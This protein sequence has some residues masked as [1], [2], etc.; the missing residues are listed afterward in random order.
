MWSG[1]D[2]DLRQQW[3]VVREMVVLQ[4]QTPTR[5]W[6]MVYVE[7]QDALLVIREWPN[8][9]LTSYLM[10]ELRDHTRRRSQ[11]PPEP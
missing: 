7:E 5:E 2:P 1:F 6:P 8:G 11:A 3:K 10:S 9:S 4:R